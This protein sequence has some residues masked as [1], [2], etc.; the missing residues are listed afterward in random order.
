MGVRVGK[1]GVPQ[2]NL[3][4]AA[5][6][7][8]AVDIC[9]ISCARRFCHLPDLGSSWGP[10]GFSDLGVLLG[11]S[12]GP[13]ESHQLHVL[14]SSRF[15]AAHPSAFGCRLEGTDVGTWSYHIRVSI[16][17]DR[18]RNTSHR[19]KAQILGRSVVQSMQASGSLSLVHLNLS[20]SL[21]LACVYHTYVHRITHRSRHL[22]LSSNLL[23]AHLTSGVAPTTVS[24][25]ASAFSRLRGCEIP[26]SGDPPGRPRAALRERP[27]NPPGAA[28][29]R[30]DGPFAA[31]RAR[32]RGVWIPEDTPPSI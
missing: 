32:A 29:A 7:W 14:A 31:V 22:D 23:P 25:L 26:P 30:P 12:C 5:L 13:H 27:A 28:S 2:A 19:L 11:S 8:H 24:L 3:Q 1:G 6:P 9:A 4:G 18:F 21:S 15:A 10:L 17:R 16:L 20:L